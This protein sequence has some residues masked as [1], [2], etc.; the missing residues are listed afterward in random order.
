M[1]LFHKMLVERVHTTRT[2]ILGAPT[3]LWRQHSARLI[4]LS[5]QKKGLRFF[6]TVS[7][8]R[9]FNIVQSFSE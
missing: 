8:R 1:E 7:E 6:Y 2:L 5:S 3:L 9:D 4:T